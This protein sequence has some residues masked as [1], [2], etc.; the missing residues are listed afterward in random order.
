MTKTH[1]LCRFLAGLNEDSLSSQTWDDMPYKLLDWAGCAVGALD[2]ANSRTAL[3]LL[4]E[5]GGNPQCSAIGLPNK[6]SMSGAAFTNGVLGHVLEYDD[7]NKIAITHPGAPVIPA[8]LAAAEAHCRTYRDFAVGVVAGYEAMIRIGAAL[9][10]SHYEHWHTTGTC[11]AFAAAAAASVVKGY[12]ADQI[13]QAMGIAATTA[14]GLTCVFGTDAKLV[15]VG[16]AARN[17]LLATELAGRGMTGPVGILDGARSYPA[18]TC[19]EE[20][21]S[22][23]VPQPGDPLCIEDSYYKMHASCGHTH[24]ALD[25]LQELLAQH[26]F[27]DS[28]VKQITIH[29]YRKALDLTGVFQVENE[30]KAKFSMPF[31]AAAMIICGQVTLRE[32]EEDVLHSPQVEAL[33][34]KIRVIEDPAY[35][36]NYPTLR[37]ERVEVTLNDRTLI[38]ELDLPNGKP[39]KQFLEN[40]FNSLAAPIIGVDRADSLRCAILSASR[41]MHMPL[42]GDALRRYSCYGK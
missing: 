27:I 18:A 9:N 16:N 37:T 40:K 1:E 13:E 26:C 30:S 42:L 25:A 31:C 14:A 11:G 22:T 19:R 20:D 8:V 17:G 2:R 35:T 29:V 21:F 12:S 6:T 7:V 34:A 4:L 5:E 32:F 23:L 10:P 39:S 41:D 15:T 24:S 3:G 36:S 33:A 38:K 28:D